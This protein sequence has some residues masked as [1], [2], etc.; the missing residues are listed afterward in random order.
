MMIGAGFSRNAEALAHVRIKQ[1]D[2]L[3]EDL[4]CRLQGVDNVESRDLA[5]KTPMRHHGWRVCLHSSR[6]RDG[7]TFGMPE[8]LKRPSHII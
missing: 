3:G 8:T 6:W 4:Y 7:Y 5:F 2:D 1:W